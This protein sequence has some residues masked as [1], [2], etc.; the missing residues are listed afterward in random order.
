MQLKENQKNLLREISE[1]CDYFSPESRNEFLEK[2]RN[3]IES[4]VTEIFDV[5][6]CLIESQEWIPLISR[7]I[8]VT[9]YTQWYDHDKELWRNRSEIAYYLSSYKLHADSAATVIRE[10]WHCE[11][12][13]HYVR[14]VSLGEDTS[15]IRTR[16]GIFARFRSFALNILRFNDVKNV[17]GAL[18]D[19]AL[20]FQGLIGMRGILSQNRTALHQP[21]FT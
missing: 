18:F 21:I 8:R 7:A 4:R 12:R 1:G 17:K 13:N 2:S 5:R 15:R 11:N 14:D 6:S 16:P 10:H 3:R 20:D 19:N 9:R